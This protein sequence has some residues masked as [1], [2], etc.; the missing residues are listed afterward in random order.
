MTTFMTYFPHLC[1]CLFVNLGMGT[2]VVCIHDLIDQ[3]SDPPQLKLPILQLS[4][5]YDCFFNDKNSMRLY[6]SSLCKGPFLFTFMKVMTK[7]DHCTTPRTIYYNV[8]SIND[9]LRC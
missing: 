6:K 1:T 3:Y 8:Q 5:Y 4:A 2:I 9:V 7:W